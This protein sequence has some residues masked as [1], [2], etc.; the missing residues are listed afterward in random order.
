MTDADNALIEKFNAHG[1]G[2]I[3][4]FLSELNAIEKEALLEQIRGIDLAELEDLVE[5]YVKHDVP[6]DVDFSLMEPSAYVSHPEKKPEL[7]PQWETA[8]MFGEE[9]LRHGRVAAFTVAGGQGTRLGYDGPKGTFSVSPVSKA[10]LFE[11]FAKKIGF[12]E[13]VYG[14]PVYW[15]I[16]TSIVN[17]EETVSFFKKNDYFGLEHHR[18]H[19]FSQGLMPAVDFD[20]KLILENKHQLVMTP[21]GHGGALRA[22]NRSG[23]VKLMEELGIQVISYFQVDNP[24]V[25]VV[26][27]YFIGFHLQQKAELSS[28]MIPKAY[29]LEKSGIFAIIR[30][31]RWSWNTATCQ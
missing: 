10:T 5:K 25:K 13:K 11:V 6:L 20:G 31:S 17:H 4:Q 24:L 12:A 7:A 15:F 2:H 29:P 8:K 22:L 14:A 3:F 26:D 27:P 19:F 18:V 16:M 28:K 9:A 21:D 30:A 1:Q 23:A